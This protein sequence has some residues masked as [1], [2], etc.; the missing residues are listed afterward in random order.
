MAIQNS[1]QNHRGGYKNFFVNE[2]PAACRD[3]ISARIRVY[4]N[5]LGY[6]SIVSHNYSSK[7]LQL[8]LILVVCT[9][10]VAL[11]IIWY[12]FWGKT[13]IIA[14]RFSTFISI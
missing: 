13:I 11:G 4:E 2:C 5:L 12:F 14:V 8:L 3:G 6:N 1:S 7:H 9:V 10:F